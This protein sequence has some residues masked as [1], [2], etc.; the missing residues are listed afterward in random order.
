MMAPSAPPSPGRRLRRLA[1]VAVVPVLVLGVV[2]VRANGQSAPA[3]SHGTSPLLGHRAPTLS[4]ATLG[5]GRYTYRPGAVTVVNI[6]ASWC[7]PCRS[8]LPTLVRLAR[9]W[10]DQGV[11]VTTIDTRDGVALA[12]RFLR[13]TGGTGLTAVSDPDGVLAVAWG[14]TGVPETF[15]I[16]ADGIVRAHW[17]GAVD[18]TWLS[19]E[20]ADARARRP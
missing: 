17:N 1:V 6:W 7:S 13:Q 5:G 16:D 11:A 10:S 3:S 14:A 4:G 9:Q 8:E 12:S 15:V 20:V 19:R 18:A 2:L